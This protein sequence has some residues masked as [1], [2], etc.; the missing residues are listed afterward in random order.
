MSKRRFR[1]FCAVEAI[2]DAMHFA[3]FSPLAVWS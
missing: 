3:P 1:F 2:R